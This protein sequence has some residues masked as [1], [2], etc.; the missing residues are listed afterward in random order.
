MRSATLVAFGVGRYFGS[1]MKICPLA[2]PADGLL[3]AMTLDGYGV[4]DFLRHLP[5]LKDGTY[6]R[7]PGR[8][9]G[10]RWERHVT[11]DVEV[12][13]RRPGASA[14]VLVELEGEVLGHAPF[15]VRSLPGALKLV[16]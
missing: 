5:R 1:G 2:E 9:G 11:A 14:E 4:W 15:R 6:V 16:M 7:V 10:A 13:C 8:E 3:D 12:L